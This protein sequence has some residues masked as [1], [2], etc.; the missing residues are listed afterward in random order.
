MVGDAIFG[1]K[2]A[3][4]PSARLQ[5]L[6]GLGWSGACKLFSGLAQTLCSANGRQCVRAS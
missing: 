5:S 4:F 2:F 3:P 6:V 1:A